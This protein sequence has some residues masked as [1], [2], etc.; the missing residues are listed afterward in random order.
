MVSFKTILLTM[1]PVVMAQ[2]KTAIGTTS[3]F[4]VCTVDASPIYSDTCISLNQT[5]STQ[6]NVAV[7]CRQYG[8]TACTGSYSTVGYRSGCYQNNRF[9]QSF[10]TISGSIYCY[11]S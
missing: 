10:G 8:N 2:N 5:G 4:R 1:I 3:E 6:F 11:P 7:G 9:F